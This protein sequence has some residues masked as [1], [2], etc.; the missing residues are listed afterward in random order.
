MR[1]L[2][3]GS[4]S[5]GLITIPVKLYSAVEDRGLDFDYLHKKDLE[6]IRYARVCKADGRE[7]P[8]EDIVRGYE[9]E[10]GDYV[11]LTDEDFRRASPRKSGTIDLVSFSDAAEIDPIYYEK[12]YYL[13][14]AKGAEKSYALLRDALSKS[15]KVGVATFVL[16]NREHVAVLRPYGKVLLVEQLRF[17]SEIRE[18][19]DLKLPRAKATEKETE[20]A[21][22]LIGHLTQPFDPAQF[23]DTYVEDLKE[24]I[25]EKARGREPKR[26]QEAPALEPTE[27][28]DLMRLLRASLRKERPKAFH[29]AKKA[30]RSRD[31]A[32]V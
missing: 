11:V 4:V 21:L 30:A 24:V 14:P 8:Y 12:A 20:M 1:A 22:T 31:T 19:K 32:R 16:R 13:E 23:R 3:S 26:R 7:V 6:P 17:R 2:W 27:V 10:K 29:K 18:P 15:G 9:F 28:K 5:F 25:A